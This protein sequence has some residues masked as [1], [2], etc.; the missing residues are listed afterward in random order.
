[1]NAT[2]LSLTLTLLV[3]FAAG[4]RAEPPLH[5]FAVVAGANDGGADRVPL[6]YATSDARSFARVLEELGGVSA[7]DIT[8]LLDGDAAALRQ[9]LARAAESI[10]KARASGE[11][12]Q[13]LLYYSGHSD[14]EG[15][16]LRGQRVP[17]TELREWLGRLGAEVRIAVLDSCSSGALTRG[18]GGRRIPAFMSDTSAQVSGHAFLTSSSADEASQ[19]SDRLRASFFTHYLVS[20]LR[21]AADLSRDGR[22]TLSEAYQFAF[23]ETLARTEKTQQGAQ[24]PAFDLQL[25]GTGEVVVTDLRGSSAGLYLGEELGGRVFV[26]DSAGN[27]VA[28]LNKA[29]GHAVELGLEPGDYRVTVERKAGVLLEGTIRVGAGVRA[30]VR[31]EALAV[32]PVE[33]TASRGGPALPAPYAAPSAPIGGPYRDAP[34]S[35]SVFGPWDI[36][37][38]VDQARVNFALSLAWSHSAA[39]AGIAISPAVSTVRDRVDGFQVAGFVTTAGGP[40]RGLQVSSGY[41]GA[42]SVDLGLQVA[43]LV[44]NADGAL[45]GLQVGGVL[46]HAREVRGFQ[47]NGLGSVASDAKVPVLGMQVAGV[48]N[49][50]PGGLG[51]FQVAGLANIAG[52]TSGGQV[53]LVNVAGDVNGAQV[54]LVNVA[55]T[56]RGAQV[57]LVNVAAHMHGVAVGLLSIAPEIEVHPQVWADELMLANAGVV[58]G[59]RYWHSM[60]AVGGARPLTGSPPLSNLPVRWGLLWGL[61]LGLDF[62]PGF[63]ELD[64]TITSISENNRFFFSDGPSVAALRAT[65]GYRFAPRLAL[66]AGLTQ[67]FYIP[68]DLQTPEPP[69]VL[70]LPITPTQLGQVSTWTGGFVGVRF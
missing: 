30:P 67:S 54:G 1:M 40:M 41:A 8:L 56:V 64:A 60:V 3:P 63:G 23:Q 36:A 53:S 6:K 69:P 46:G 43:G 19:E 12:V 9:A 35:L 58:I 27:L 31:G 25:A 50:A 33:L 10:Q 51:G 57:G 59:T 42:G 24:H 11:R 2:A 44:A 7:R 55:G 13:L 17:Y 4:A 65:V 22:V 70:A 21:G 68:D 48:V 15:L 29:A 34:L 14:E 62:G 52:N 18:K 5:R 16:L 28:E 20:G 61:G 38:P 32:Q 37:A 49:Y 26:R 47:V 39:L 66:V 45:N